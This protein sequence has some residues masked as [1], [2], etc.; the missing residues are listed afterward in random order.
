[1]V[2]YNY[3]ESDL[4]NAAAEVL[5]G[6]PVRAAARHHG[7]LTSTLRSRL[8]GSLPKAVANTLRSRLSLVQE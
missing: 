5:N 8:N 2:S 1:M 7:V 6:A 4:R 3:T